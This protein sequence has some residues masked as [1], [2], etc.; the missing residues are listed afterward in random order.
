MDNTDRRVFFRVKALLPIQ[1]RVVSN[2]EFEELESTLKSGLPQS[3]LFEEYAPEV[4]S[5]STSSTEYRDLA[6]RIQLLNR[7]LDTILNLLLNDRLPK[8][9][10]H[11]VG[12]VE[13]SGGGLKF[14]SK[15][16]FDEGNRADVRMIL[17][18]FPYVT[19]PVLC[20]VARSHQSDSE[21][22]EVVLKFL[23]I[24]EFDRDL[25]I[26]F[27]FAK[28]QQLIRAQRFCDDD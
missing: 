20:E 19:I 26:K 8:D 10:L 22:F 23:Q 13:L 3:I 27:I 15:I 5:A 9:F 25:L 2:A 14:T 18:I 21:T 1:I 4:S 28:E 17:P 7:K 6:N 12:D 16:S 11:I 24:S